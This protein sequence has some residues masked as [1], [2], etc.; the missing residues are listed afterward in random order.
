MQNLISSYGFNMEIPDELV[1][2]YNGDVKEIN[3]V[4]EAIKLTKEMETIKDDERVIKLEL[5][6]EDD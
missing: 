5:V 4:L 2:I 1:D 3:E 6:L